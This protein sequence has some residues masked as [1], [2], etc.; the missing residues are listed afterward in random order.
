[1]SA[2]GNAKSVTLSWNAPAGNGRPITSV[3]VYIDGN[4]SSNAG[5]GTVTV[6]DAYSEKHSIRVV[7]KDSAGQTSENSTSA[8]SGDAPPKGAFLSSW[9]SCDGEGL[10]NGPPCVRMKI[11][12]ENFLGQ[13][14]VTCT[15]NSR[16][17][18]DLTTT[19]PVD[20]NGNGS[21]NL[22]WYTQD[23]GAYSMENQASNMSCEG[24]PVK[25]RR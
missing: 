14:S 23:T 18:G 19:I 10:T 5:N 11:T 20:G 9:R 15:W 7:V 21:K 17:D 2:N 1:V 25:V 12:V 24:T 22:S 6:G 8:S 3:E 13:G 4:L 16:T